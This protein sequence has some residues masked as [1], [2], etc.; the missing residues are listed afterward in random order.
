MQVIRTKKKYSYFI[1]VQIFFPVKKEGIPYVVLEAM[2]C[3]LP[4]CQ[5]AKELINGNSYISGS[6]GF[7]DKV[8]ELV[9]DDKKRK[10]IGFKSRE[11]L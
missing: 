11:S 3:G 7:S 5:K 4:Q 9:D 10:V 1:R 8:I 2:V 6:D